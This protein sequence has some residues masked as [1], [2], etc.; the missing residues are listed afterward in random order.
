MKKVAVIA[1]PHKP[2]IHEA[3]EDLRVW[4]RRHSVELA[5]NTD[6][7]GKT[8]DASTDEGYDELARRFEAADAAVTLG[9]DGTLLYA[10]QLVGQL[11]IP[12]LPVNLGSLGYHT[13]ATPENMLPR[14][15][16]VAEGRYRTENRLLL[17][18]YI[19]PASQ[20]GTP[21]LALNDVVVS[22]RVWG[23][24]IHL[25]VSIDGHDVTDLSADAIIFSTPTGSSAYNYAAGG[26]ILA[27]G[28][29]AIVINAVCPHR[30]AFAPL[31][32]SGSADITV[33]VH[34]REPAEIAQVLVDGQIWRESLLTETL[35]ISRSPM[36]LP[37][38]LFEDDFFLKMRQKLAWGVLN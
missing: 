34:R 9:G 13:Q 32:L 21:R 11:N 26:P 8:I 17:Q 23:R 24:M 28:L 29:D 30:I 35:K 36:Y 25:R 22:K 33:T 6:G 15:D 10:V 31:V 16:A 3:M 27:P 14:L 5:D 20:N 18:T 19:E 37:V 1:N 38:I 4:A 7:P 2:G 12:V